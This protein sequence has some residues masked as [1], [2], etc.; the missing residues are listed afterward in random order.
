[1][2]GHALTPNPQPS[3]GLCPGRNRD[4]NLAV[5]RRD[6]DLRTQE[7]LRNRHRQL[8][9]QIALFSFKEPVF[10]HA[11]RQQK[12]ARRSSAETGRALAGESYPLP[13]LDTPRYLHIES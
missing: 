8:E 11:D 1:M 10:G 2:G 5:E 7:R 13:V 12:V 6:V 4:P 9:L 3:T